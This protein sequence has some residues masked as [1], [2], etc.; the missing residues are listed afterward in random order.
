MT[1]SGSGAVEQPPGRLEAEARS[2]NHR[3]LKV[4]VR[5]QGPLPL[6]DRAVEERFR[7]RAERGHVTVSLRFR[8]N[9]GAAAAG[10]DGA[11]FAVAAARLAALAEAAGL[12]AP[13]VGDVLARARRPLRRP[14]GDRGGAGRGGGARRAG[15]LDRPLAESRQREGALLVRELEALLARVATNAG[16]VAELAREVPAAVQ[17]RLLARLRAL[18]AGSEISPD[19]AAA[20]AGGRAPR[21]P[22]RRAGGGRAPRGPRRPR[23]GA[24]GGGGL[25]SDDAS[26]SWSRRCTGKRTRIGSKSADLEVTRTVVDLKAD[27]ERLREQVQNLE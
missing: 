1:G 8:A 4:T 11:A 2:V 14:P 19:P 20:G 17:G 16:R 23:P 10:V 18:L 24:A 13:T 12:P 15:P 26:T 5:T 9:P 22:C 25:Q 21:R 6:M 3:F 27:V 7:G